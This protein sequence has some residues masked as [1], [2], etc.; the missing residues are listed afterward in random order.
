[1][2]TAPGFADVSVQLTMVGLN[3]PAYFTFG[4][5]PDGG[6]PQDAATAVMNAITFTGSLVSQFDNGMTVSQVRV[7]MGQ[8]GSED[9]VGQISGTTTGTQTKSTLPPN[10]AVLIH[11]V[12]ARGGRRGRGRM[13]LPWCVDESLV[14]EAGL[15]QNSAVTSLQTACSLFLA[16]LAD[17]SVPMVLLHGVGNTLPGAPNPVTA[18]TV[19]K[20]ISTQRRRLGRR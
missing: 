12:T 7:S 17:F 16:K 2:P 3:R 14:D 9:L 15:I 8:D 5:D 19:D 10:V 1:M 6:T 13:F 4:I 11:K 20:L 18:L